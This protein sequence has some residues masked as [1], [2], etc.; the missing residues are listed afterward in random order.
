MD[1]ADSSSVLVGGLADEVAQWWLN[2]LNKLESAIVGDRS[3][4]MARLR[5]FI[6]AL[7]SR[8]GQCHMCTLHLQSPLLL[9]NNLDF[10]PAFNMMSQCADAKIA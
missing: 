3:P 8:Y 10:P 7:Q 9:S 2:F 1:V 6:A 4:E 5:A